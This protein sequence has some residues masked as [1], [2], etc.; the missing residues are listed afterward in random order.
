MRET[1]DG[2]GEGRQEMNCDA[3]A[4][5]SLICLT[6][7]AFA[8]CGRRLF[9]C[10]LLLDGRWRTP[11]MTSLAESS[12]RAISELGGVSRNMCYTLRVGG[13]AEGLLPVHRM[14]RAEYMFII[15]ML[16]YSS[17]IILS[18]II[19][20]CQLLFSADNY[21]YNNILIYLYKYAINILQMLIRITNFKYLC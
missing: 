6:A 20:C 10:L 18:L 12:G 17:K 11:Q 9:D 16:I 2:T 1:D 13:L 21:K 7:F 3:S 14:S 19:I 15:G 5:C 4:H 8:F